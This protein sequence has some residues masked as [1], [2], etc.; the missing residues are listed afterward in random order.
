M[1]AVEVT[2]TLNDKETAHQT[3]GFAQTNFAGAIHME[4]RCRCVS[5]YLSRRSACKEVSLI[6][7]VC[8]VTAQR[9]LGLWSFKQHITMDMPQGLMQ[10]VLY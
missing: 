5:S 7:Q 6:W 1:T 3:N 4:T 2:Q 9:V 8:H 10:N